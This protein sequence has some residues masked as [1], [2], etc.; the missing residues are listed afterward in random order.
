MQQV[1][2]TLSSLVP[3]YFAMKWYRTEM[4]FFITSL[5][6]FASFLFPSEILILF[7]TK[8]EASGELSLF[9]Y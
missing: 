4:R 6:I 9:Y 8:N 3:Y 5:L 7:L 2:Y 1:A